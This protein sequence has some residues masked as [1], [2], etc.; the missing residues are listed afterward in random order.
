MY[1]TAQTILSAVALTSAVTPIVGVL[2]A[3]YHWYQ[4]SVPFDFMVD[5][6]AFLLYNP[7]FDS[8]RED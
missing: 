5:N 8:L 4:W 6:P 3:I 7:V 2:F 1:I